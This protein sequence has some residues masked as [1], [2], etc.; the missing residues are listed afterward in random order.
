MFLKHSHTLWSQKTLLRC[1]NPDG[2]NEFNNKQAES[3]ACTVLGSNPHWIS[4]GLSSEELQACAFTSKSRWA[5]ENRVFTHACTKMGNFGVLGVTQSSLLGAGCCFGWVFAEEPFSLGCCWH[6]ALVWQQ[7]TFFTNAFTFK[8][9]S[10]IVTQWK[11]KS[12]AEAWL[13]TR[14]RSWD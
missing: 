14:L 10:L 4:T 6:P 3:R 7:E 12:A 2:F 5:A 9:G 8:W 11:P 1:K 13:H